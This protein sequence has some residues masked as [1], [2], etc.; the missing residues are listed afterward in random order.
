M[1]ITP[2]KALKP[3]VR[4][5][6]RWPPKK[7]RL[8]LHR[9]RIERTAHSCD[10]AGAWTAG[11]S[12]DWAP[13]R[14]GPCPPCQLARFCSRLFESKAQFAGP[15]APAGKGTRRWRAALAKG[16]SYSR[17]GPSNNRRATDADPDRVE[18]V[19]SIGSIGV[20]PF[21][22]M[23]FADVRSIDDRS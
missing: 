21:G 18:F 9:I 14:R 11:L 4:S 17:R 13:T 2:S 10:A 23:H 22:M 3:R 16:N 15:G 19:R 12:K 5:I 6:G 7:L 8:V 1:A 20:L